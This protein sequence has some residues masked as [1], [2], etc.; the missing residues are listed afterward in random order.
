MNEWVKE[1]VGK[2]RNPLPLA[3]FCFIIK[4]RLIIDLDICNNNNY[5]LTCINSH[6]ELGIEQR[7]RDA[8]VSETYTSLPSGAHSPKEGSYSYQIIA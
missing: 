3:R 5:E 7:G 1:N 2:S 6:Y 4:T 8:V